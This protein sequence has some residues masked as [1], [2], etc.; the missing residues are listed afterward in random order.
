MI[1][2]LEEELKI[3]RFEDSEYK[4]RSLSYFAGFRV[5]V[6]C[7]SDLAEE[8]AKVKHIYE[9]DVE[10]T[11]VMKAPDHKYQSYWNG[12]MMIRVM[13]TKK[14]GKY[15]MS[16][17]SIDDKCRSGYKTHIATSDDFLY[18]QYVGDIEQNY[19][20]TIYFFYCF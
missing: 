12:E 10:I 20:E 4:D 14:H 8:Q 16:F 9:D 6:P 18:W 3:P 11:Y 5:D 7:D 13:M 15:Y 2:Q 19:Q 1:K 17:V